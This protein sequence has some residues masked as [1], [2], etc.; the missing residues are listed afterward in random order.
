MK[1]DNKHKSV[2]PIVKKVD[3]IV[4]RMKENKKHKSVNPIVKRKG[5]MSQ[6]PRLRKMKEGDVTLSLMNGPYYS[7]CSASSEYSG[8]EC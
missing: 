1:G 7:G 4:K 8:W 2:D 6:H 3:P 5:K